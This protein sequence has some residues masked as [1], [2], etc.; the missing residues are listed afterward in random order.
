MSLTYDLNI[1]IKIPDFIKKDFPKSS[2]ERMFR[3]FRRK[4]K[5]RRRKR[6]KRKGM[7]IGA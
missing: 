2:E 4:K 6:I 1:D 3:M 5:S 7:K